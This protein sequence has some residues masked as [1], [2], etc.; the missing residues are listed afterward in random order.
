MS[1]LNQFKVGA[2]DYSTFDLSHLH[3][4]TGDMGMLIPISTKMCLP[5]DKWKV[6]VDS[7]VRGMPTIVPILDKVD[8]K[9]NHFYVPYRVLWNR[10]EEWYTQNNTW[11]GTG[12][13]EPTPPVIWVSQQINPGAKYPSGRLS[14][15]LGISKYWK[16][17]TGVQDP[18]PISAFPHLAYQKIFLDYY[19]P[20]RWVQ[21]LQDN[22]TAHELATLR[23]QLEK[24][25]RGDGG[26]IGNF[27][28]N[29]FFEKMRYVGWNHD[30]FTNALPTPELFDGSRILIQDP[31]RDDT[32]FL[33]TEP[34]GS[35]SRRTLGFADSNQQDPAGYDNYE[36]LATVRDLRRS[37]AVQH[38]YEAL[39]YSGGRYMETHK[40]IWGQDIDNHTLQR[41]QYIG[42]DVVSLFVNEV[43]STASTSEASLGDLAGK[44]VGGGQSSSE[45]FECDEFGIY[46]AIA[47]VVP[48]R[49]YS[50]AM[51][52]SLFFTTKAEDLPNPL[53][54]GIG[55][56]AVY[57]YE[58]TG[59]AF[60]GEGERYQNIF[61]YVPRFS[62][63]KTSLDRFSGEM[64]NSLLHWHMGTT[65]EELDEFKTVSP[66]F[67]KCNPRNDIFQ[68]PNESDK[69]IMAFQLNA[70][71]Q[72]KLAINP[73]PGMSWI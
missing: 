2:K 71:V 42:G 21:Y 16:K 59:K 41:S 53:F 43:E 4:T 49:S 14:D 65:A 15:Y 57:K 66:E 62:N 64:R 1:A 26:G 27:N 17:Q 31:T 72:R 28:T 25:R 44:P 20:Q 54:Q 47:H 11:K 12:Q 18:P 34:T 45:F 6:S 69:I 70:T 73:M 32:G 67:I 61:G 9:I 29:A 38:Y 48:K 23:A 37:I 22:G 52:R 5:G 40:V 46:M 24:V 58:L 8:I 68:V 30:Y 63:F 10:F 56:E 39:S 19:A 35:E 7:F 60:D 50:D 3:R 36:K 51:D 13:A 33:I 55:D